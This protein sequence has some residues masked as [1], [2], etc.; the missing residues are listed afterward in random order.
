PDP[1]KLHIHPWL[2]HGAPFHIDL[3]S[4]TFAP[5]PLAGGPYWREGT[6]DFTE[7]AFHPP[8]MSLQI[9]HPRLPFWPVELAPS[10]AGSNSTP[11]MNISNVLRG[12]HQGLHKHMGQ[13]DWN[14]LTEGDQ[15]AVTG[16]FKARCRAEAVR[17]GGSPE[18][19]RN[20]EIKTISEG[21]RRV[22]FLQGRTMFKGLV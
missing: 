2:T 18:Q 19:L 1:T 13:V 12:L 21:V 4:S 11:M 20:W 5:L 22:D 9:V 6:E 3:A 14:S 17:I 15:Q 16:A 7:S 8:L 10:I